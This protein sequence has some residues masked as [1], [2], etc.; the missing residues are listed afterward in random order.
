M[1]DAELNR[2][3]KSVEPPHRPKEYWDEFPND[4]SRQ[5]NRPLPRER[6]QTNWLPRLAWAGSFAAICVL[7][8][9]LIG[10]HLGQTKLADANG[11]SLQNEKLIREV[12]AMFPNRVRA[13]LKDE[14][15]LHLVLA[16]D[17]DVPASTPLWVK[18]CQGAQCTTL[19]TFSGQEVDVAGQKMTVL[20]D[21][22]DGVILVGDRFA[23]ASD[24]TNGNVQDLKIQAK[25]LQIALK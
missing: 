20:A 10:H 18:I 25:P 16:D 3:L 1:N 24:E 6:R 23:W 9:I 14:A 19:V 12:M 13:I 7:T 21:A 8:G 22:E 4:M 17:A 11:Q 2:I 5:L 15:G